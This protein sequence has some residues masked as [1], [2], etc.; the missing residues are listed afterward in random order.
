MVWRLIGLLSPWPFEH[1]CIPEI[2]IWDLRYTQSLQ[3]P[4]HPKASIAKKNN[5]VSKVNSLAEC[6]SQE[7]FWLSYFHCDDTR[8]GLRNDRPKISIRVPLVCHREDA[9]ITTY[10]VPLVN[11]DPHDRRHNHPFVH[12]TSALSRRLARAAMQT[13]TSS[14]ALCKIGFDREFVFSD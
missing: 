8:L 5:A 2:F 13:K 6:G 12:Q 9:W 4:F 1:L 7:N 10:T 11:R 14:F 3:G